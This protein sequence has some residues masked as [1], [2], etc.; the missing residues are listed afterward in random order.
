MLFGIATNGMFA[1]P[2][3]FHEMALFREA[4]R[5]GSLPLEDC[6][7]YTPTV[8]PS[9]HHEWGTGAILYVVA[10][11]LGAIGVLALAYT[12]LGLTLGVILATARRKGA[13]WTVLGSVAPVGVVLLGSA[14]TVFRA[15]MFTLAAMALL[16]YALERDRHGWRAWILPWLAVW[17]LWLNL[18]GGFVVGLALLAAHALEQALRRKPVGHLVLVAMAMLAL[19]A[20]NPYGW[21]YYP[22]LATALTMDRPLIT[23]WWPVWRAK[24][25]PLGAFVFAVLIAAYAILKRGPRQSHGILVLAATAWA[26]AQHQRHLSLLAVAWIAYVP[27]LVQGTA[28]GGALESFWTSRPTVARLSWAG[29]ALLALASAWMHGPATLPVP[30]NPWENP[31]ICY[32]VGAAE[33]LRESR[34]RGNLMVPFTVGAYVSW[35]LH[36]DVQVSIDGRY[37]VA[38]QPGVLERIHDFYKAAPDWWETLEMYPTDAVLVPRSSPVEAPLA[39]IGWEY[40]YVDEAY[41]VLTPRPWT[42]EQDRD[43]SEVHWWWEVP[44]HVVV[45]RT[46]TVLHGTFP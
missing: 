30:A 27:S 25:L 34:F 5:R 4:L 26:A 12:F 19:V 11:K 23:E 21:R 43:P 7:A 15:Q 33:F 9:I 22:Y 20:V 31:H 13:S 46:G 32:P 18:H 2:D 41:A 1:D 3:M 29:V 40:V 28:I 42:V 24:S 14:A 38:Y 17:L 45:D 36:P 10:T 35:K 8:S 16:L 6:F 44:S 39:A 37:E